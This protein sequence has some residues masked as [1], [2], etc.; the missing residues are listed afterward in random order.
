MHVPMNSR[1]LGRLYQEAHNRMRDVEGLL[2]QEAFDEL[3]KFLF[4]KD[5]TELRARLGPL[6][7]GN[8]SPDGP[9][10]MR[11]QLSRELAA[12]A[13]W[14]FQL[15]PGGQFNL[16][17]SSLVGLQQLF[18]DLQLSGLAL[19][20]RSTALSTFLDADVRKG[21]GIFPTP[22]TI[23]QT[24]I[25]VIDPRPGDIVLDPACGTGT[26]L[27]ETARHLWSKESSRE[28][29][30]VY[31][32]EK[33][34]RMLLLSDLNLGHKE[35]L[36]FE[37][38]CADS[39]QT[40]GL[41]ND[42]PLGLKPNSVDVILTNPPFGVT[43]TQSAMNPQLFP[44]GVVRRKAGENRIPSEVLF[45]KLCLRLLRPGGKLGIILPRSVITNER[46]SRHRYDSDQNG[47]LTEIIDLPPEAFA[48]T[49]TQTTTVAAFFRKHLD[50][51]EHL[52]GSVRV[53]RVTNVGF[54]STG[55]PREGSQLAGLATK[56]KESDR[57]GEPTVTSHVDVPLTETLQQAATLLFRS[58][59]HRNGKPLRE[60]V[61][62]ANT[63]RTPARS[64]YAE[65][66]T[67]IL[68]VGNLTGRG[69]D[70][71][72]RDRNFVS[73]SE[74]IKRAKNPKLSLRKGDLLLTSSAHS[75][76]Y[77]AK[78]VDVVA[79]VP[80]GYTGVTFVGEVIRLRAANGVDPF[81]LLAALRHP[82]VQEDLQACVR[83]QTAH[84]HPSDLLET[85]VPYDLRVPSRDLVEVA[86]LLRREADLAFELN[87]VAAQVSR[88]LR[89]R[90]PR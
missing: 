30:T 33:N 26:F 82:R 57:V 63:G 64:A 11:E 72:P 53:C 31:G 67:F 10:E 90:A 66:G 79:Y 15:W 87:S 70:W 5:C 50:T 49:G 35:G 84:L 17:D 58:N 2:P 42:A 37:R 51:G 36:V 27:L 40:L 61:E 75:A 8:R 3:L 80:E 52:T 78:K 14:A 85:T 25:E 41:S 4:W 43:V 55:R 28:K 19:D 39:L 74:G 44:T 59:A 45:L 16:S 9:G 1:T 21:L 32:V 88:K 18:A 54:D 47:H 62:L 38:A 76:R 86:N 22:E 71:E 60:F 24:M 29:L 13:P 6:A 65:Q 73:R 12:R 77:I 48:S 68:K 81:V 34:P 89:Q 20:V 7:T 83:G 23:V 69:I 46:L 56:L